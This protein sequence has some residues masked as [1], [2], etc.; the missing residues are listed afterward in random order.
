MALLT[1]TKARA[2]KPDGRPLPHGGVPGLRLLPTK[3]K[4]RGKW[5]LRF[6]SPLTGKRRDAGLGS[7][8]EV[9]IAAAKEAAEEMRKQI[10]AGIDPL[11]VKRAEAAAPKMPTF[12]EAARTLHAELLPGWK[13]A[14]HGQQWIN[15]LAQFI[16]PKIGAL[17]LDAIAPKHVADALRPIWMEKPETAARTKQRMHAVM[18]WGWAH[19]FVS[20]NPV[21]VVDYLLPQQPGKAARTLHQPAMPWRDVPAWVAEHLHG[22][23]RYD[24]TRPM[25]EFL[26]LTAAR[27]GEVR[28]ATWAEIDWEAGLWIVPASRMKAKQSHVVPLSD[29]ALAI[30]RQQQ[31]MHE[32]LIFPSPRDRKEVCDMVLTAF[33]RRVQAPSSTPGRIA[34]AHGFRSSFRD[35]ASANRYDRDLAEMAL[36]HA[37]GGKVEAAYH[38]ERL[39]DLRR[40]M[41]QA[42]ADFVA[43]KEAGAD[44]VVPIHARAA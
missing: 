39:L 22:A 44:N 16:F 35:W 42:W 31:G 40:P 8:P 36:A 2:L 18:A 26:I 11:E 17:P 4:G 43:G 30:L 5:E 20:A 41:M 21:D 7:Y 29:R 13:N 25:L 1:D 38:R 23:D 12:E 9:G 27:S 3:T 24:V 19:G 33:L 10:A 32:T 34:T 15:T 6:V 37:V 14:K 28:G